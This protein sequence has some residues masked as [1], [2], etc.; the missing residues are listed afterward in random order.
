MDWTTKI[1]NSIRICGYKDIQIMEIRKSDI[2]QNERAKG[3]IYWQFK[4]KMQLIC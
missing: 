2:T 1:L 3:L 4:L